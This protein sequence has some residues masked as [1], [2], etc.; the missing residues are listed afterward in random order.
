MLTTEEYLEIKSKIDRWKS[1]TD[2]LSGMMAEVL[3]TLNSEFNVTTLDEAKELLSKMS[4][5]QEKL[6][7]Q[8][9]SDYERFKEKWGDVLR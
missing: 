3:R 7:T 1:K 4:R 2:K 9:L 5:R 6:E 8:F